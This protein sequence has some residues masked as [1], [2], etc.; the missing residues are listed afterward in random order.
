MPPVPEN[1]TMHSN[2]AKRTIVKKPTSQ[3]WVG[4]DQLKW[5][6]PYLRDVPESTTPTQCRVTG[7]FPSWI[8]GSFIRC[9]SDVYENGFVRY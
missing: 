6:P 8:E 3:W 5:V 2:G 7:T 9:E 4:P 1:R